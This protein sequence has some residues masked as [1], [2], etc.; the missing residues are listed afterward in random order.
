MKFT[1]NNTEDTETRRA[2]RR[3]MFESM[4]RIQN[5]IPNTTLRDLR[6]SVPSVFLPPNPPKRNHP[7]IG[8]EIN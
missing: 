3:N 6:V 1:G 5:R 7:M 8:T 2:R 4:I